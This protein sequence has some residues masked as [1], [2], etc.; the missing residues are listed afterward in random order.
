MPDLTT[1]NRNSRTYDP[2]LLNTERRE[3]FDRVL[4]HYDSG[5]PSPLQIHV[6]GVAGTGKSCLID[7]LSRHLNYHA[8]LE[9]RTSPVVLRGAPT[10]VAAYNINGST[11]HRLLSLPVNNKFEDLVPER[12]Q[13]Y[14]SAFR[15][16]WLLIID[17]KS[18]IGLRALHRIDVRLRQ[19]RHYPDLPF[20][21]LHIL[22]CGDFGQL[23][24]VLGKPLH[25]SLQQGGTE[26]EVHL[27]KRSYYAFDQTIVLKTMMHQQGDTPDARRFRDLLGSLRDGPISVQQREVLIART[28]DRLTDAEW[29]LLIVHYASSIPTIRS[30]SI[31]YV[32]SAVS[33]SLF[34]VS[35]LRMLVAGLEMGPLTIL[36]IS[37]MSFCLAK[38]PR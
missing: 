32:V 11:L 36:I 26:H 13:R 19:I 33:V 6:D 34:S 38:A 23:S 7:L 29:G 1:N 37:R 15:D 28:R 17:E 25:H 9:G 8:Y 2:L 31:I 3:V 18:M 22:F 20:G 21:G 10:G 30:A 14:Q 35:S 12:L 24:P 27:G 16:I 5:I 4:R